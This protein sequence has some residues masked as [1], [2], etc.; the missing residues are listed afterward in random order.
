MAAAFDRHVLLLPV[1]A[2]PRFFFHVTNGARELDR[3]GTELPS[4]EAAR[5]QA[6][7]FGATVLQHQPDLVLDS[8]SW[9]VEVTDETGCHLFVIAMLAMSSPQAE[10]IH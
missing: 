10:A 6:V 3:E 5:S 2:M 7:M 8:G 9:R 1:L 4:F